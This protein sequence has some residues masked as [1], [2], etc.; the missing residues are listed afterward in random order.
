MFNLRSL[1]SYSSPRL[2]V[3]RMEELIVELLLVKNVW[4]QKQNWSFMHLLCS[5]MVDFGLRREELVPFTQPVKVRRGK[6]VLA[7]QF[8]ET[9]T[10]SSLALNMSRKLPSDP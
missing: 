8:H 6:L 4:C 5:G 3:H 9:F 2:V 7:L 1:F 10:R